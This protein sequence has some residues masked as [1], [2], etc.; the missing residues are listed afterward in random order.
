MQ[1]QLSE[2]RKR[3]AEIELQDEES[4][5]AHLGEGR[6]TDPLAK[7]MAGSAFDKSDADM[8]KQYLQQFYNDTIQMASAATDAIRQIKDNEFAHEQEM[9]ELQARNLQIQ[10]EQQINAI[11]A[12]TGYTI[13]KKNQLAR[14][15]ATAA[16]QQNTINQR[17]KQINIE[18]AKFDRSA[19]EAK[20]IQD[21]AV[22]IMGIWANF[23]ENP[24][25]AGIL[26]A[27]IGATGAA[28]LAAAS[29]AP[30][31]SYRY[32][33]DAT[34]TFQ[35]IAGEANEQELIAPPGKTPYWSGTNAKLFTEPLGTSVTP[36]SQII[37]HVSSY[38]GKNGDMQQSEINSILATNLINFDRK[39][40]AMIASKIDDQTHEI[41]KAIYANANHGNIAEVVRL[42]ISKN[43]LR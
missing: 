24:V 2:R 35:F 23:P 25:M 30:I 28:E 20:I 13:E 4:H 18:K 17:E 41:V 6:F 29:S 43:K 1:K 5:K 39:T 36:I 21:T 33:T 16:A 27:L 42:E 15:N 11:N 32:G 8:Q 26:T 3:L 34:T 38:V 40:D 22:A 37:N 14:V 31:P 12:S 10:T 19:S 9:L 7:L